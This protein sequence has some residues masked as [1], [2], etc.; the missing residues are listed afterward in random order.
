[1]EAIRII[2]EKLRTYIRTS[3]NEPFNYERYLCFDKAPYLDAFIN[4][5]KVPPFEVE[6]QM[7]SRCNLSC[8]W[9]IG[10]EVQSK[11]QVLNLPNILNKNNID[12]VVDGI[13]SMR[14]NDLAIDIVKFSGFIGEPLIQKEA[15]LHAIQRFAG[16]GIKVGLFT[17]GVLLTEDTWSTL[18]N[19]E[20]VHIS[21]DAGPSTF[22]WLKE[23][24]NSRRNAFTENTFKTVIN[25][26]T[27]LHK[28][29]QRKGDRGNVKLN[30]GYVIVSGNVAEIYEA[31][32]QVKEAGADMI[33]FK[34]DIAN[35]HDLVQ[36]DLLDSVFTQIERVK[37]EFHNPPAFSVHSIHSRQEIEDHSYSNW[38]CD[39]GCYYQFFMTTIGSDGNLYF[40]DHN[41]MPGG[42]PI[43]NVI[44]HSFRD[45]WLN[46]R[47]K[48]LSNGVKYLCQS[49]V[50]P[51][52]GN[53]VNAFLHEIVELKKDYGSAA[54][55]EALNV[56]RKENNVTT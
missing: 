10:D 42:I 50:C 53:R 34:C 49:G 54:V 38:K 44:D 45:I 24:G 48:Y 32:K 15:T 1:M 40:C 46:D 51:P 29:R 21:L 39:K 36:T 37:N 4:D 22:Y 43:G 47:H 30:V 16:A 52:F 7:S 25:N 33:R 26:L 56:L 5:L 27:G 19:I 6:I 2:T 9:C 23:K 13:L 31:S 12:R 28:C 41:T 14:E 20:Y 35:I 55:I 3:Y 18:S 17:N 11:K 8:L